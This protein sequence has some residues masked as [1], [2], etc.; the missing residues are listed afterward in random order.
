MLKKYQLLKLIYY[1][2]KIS[3]G[4]RQM[5][6][7]PVKTERIYENII[8][9]IKEN[10]YNGTLKKGSKLPSERNFSE[11]LN[12]SRSV[13]RE[14]LSALEILGIVETRPGEG[15]YIVNNIS[16]AMIEILSL[17]L[18]LEH[19]NEDDFIG[20]R[21]I[22]ESECA[23]IAASMH[24]AAT[25]EDIKKH[26]DM[27]GPQFDEEQN[28]LADRNFHRAIISASKNRLVVS[29]AKAI[30]EGIDIYIISA[31]RKLMSDKEKFDMLYYQH[32]KIF[33][34]I[35]DGKPEKAREFTA[36]HIDFVQRELKRY[37]ALE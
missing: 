9:Q 37:K 32:K 28:T 21:K 19:D 30:S 16:D 25:I 36:E 13:V 14:A 33:E 17:A 15:T 23:Y 18:A 20:L 35:M 7:K 31:R 10:I 8:E 12:V 1:G 5:N 22:L 6:F 11:I 26:F 3:K 34:S 2:D 24:D 27:M 4:E 29:L